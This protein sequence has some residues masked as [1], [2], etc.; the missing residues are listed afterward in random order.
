MAHIDLAAE[1][2]VKVPVKPQLDDESDVE[3][4][5]DNNLR[6]ARNVAELV[7]I[8]GGDD[9]NADAVMEDLNV[10]EYSNFPLRD[11]MKTIFGDG[12]PHRMRRPAPGPQWARPFVDPP[13]PLAQTP[14]ALSP[15]PS[16]FTRTQPLAPGA[17]SAFFVD[18]VSVFL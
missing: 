8:G 15:D 17:V 6:R 4:D 11:A 1:A 12:A 14:F 10:G 2:R 9:G 13:S 3:S 16:S 18:R 7:D 5:D